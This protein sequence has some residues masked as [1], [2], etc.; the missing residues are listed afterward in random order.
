M[1]AA[2][3]NFFIEQG[4]NFD[5]TFQ[6]LDENNNPIALSLIDDCVVFKFKPDNIG[7]TTFSEVTYSSSTSNLNLKKLTMGGSNG[8]ILLSLKYSDTKEFG[9]D[10]AKYDLYL[11]KERNSSPTGDKKQYRLATGIISLVKVATSADIDCEPPAAS[12]GDTGD[13]NNEPNDNTPQPTATVTLQPQAD[14]IDLCSTVCGSLD[15]YST[16]YQYVG[17][18]DNSSLTINDNSIVSGQ[19]PISS[20]LKIENIQV[21]V[22]GLKHQSPQDL[23]LILIPPSG[24]GVLLAHNQKISN[25]SSS[26]AGFIFSRKA[27]PTSFLHNMSSNDPYVNIYDKRSYHPSGNFLMAGFGHLYN[28]ALSGLWTLQIADTDPLG[29][30]V[31]SGW[32]IIVQYSVSQ[33][34]DSSYVDNWD[35][36]YPTNPS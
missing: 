15:L 36:Y 22:S 4:S 21:V 9:W 8:Q 2:E 19:I 5:I 24:S 17:L 30:G 32:G 28:H 27:L 25:I 26:G 35:S 7:T 33:T 18:N 23:S 20:S 34:N 31:L 11:I 3:Y 16:L 14:T 6:Y 13:S 1:P 12:Q 10:T 29:S